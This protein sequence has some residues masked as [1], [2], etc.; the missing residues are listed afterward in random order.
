[1]KTVRKAFARSINVY[2]SIFNLTLGF[3]IFIFCSLTL[4]PLVSSYLNLGS[5][6]LRFSSIIYD[7][8]F[9]QAVIFILVGLISLAFLSLFL[10]AIITTIKLKETLDHFRFKK[11]WNAFPAYV[12]RM[13]FLLLLLSVVSIAIGTFLESASAPRE[14]Y[15]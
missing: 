15:N 4:L 1:M 2:S 3:S 9:F 14:V 13:F 7:M 10:S 12:A 6:F 5:A 11:V 8:T